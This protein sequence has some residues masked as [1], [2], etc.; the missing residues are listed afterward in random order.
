MTGHLNI[1]KTE[2]GVRQLTEL[3]PL[4][5]P[6]QV[7]MS[8]KKEITGHNKWLQANRLQ[9]LNCTADLNFLQTMNKK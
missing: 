4:D 7:T 6:I 3:M 1:M 5:E 2:K 8:C 9:K